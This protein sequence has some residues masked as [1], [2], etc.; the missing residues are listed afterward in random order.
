MPHHHLFHAMSSYP[1]YHHSFHVITTFVFPLTLI[2]FT[3]AIMSFGYSS[4]ITELL[5]TSMT[6]IFHIANM[7]VVVV[8]MTKTIIYTSWMNKVCRNIFSNNG[9][10]LIRVFLAFMAK[11]IYRS[12]EVLRKYFVLERH[13][14]SKDTMYCLKG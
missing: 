10:T 13:V 7:M 11:W 2:E 1:P 12:S 4:V 9:I 8:M 3:L 5:L 6:T 14:G